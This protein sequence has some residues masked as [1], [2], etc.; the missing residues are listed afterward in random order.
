MLRRILEW[1]E[2]VAAE[3]DENAAWRLPQRP[4]RLAHVAD[5]APAVAG[6]RNPGRTPQRHEPHIGFARGRHSV[7]RDDA[8]VGMRRVDQDVDALA[9]EVVR[10]PC[11]AAEAAAANRHA[12]ARGRSGAAGQRKRDIKVAA[13]SQAFGQQPRFR[14]AAKNEDAWHAAS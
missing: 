6:D 2:F 7:R 9:D 5:L 4:H 3:R 14:G 12:L 1:R 10:K 11:G 13:P 8:G